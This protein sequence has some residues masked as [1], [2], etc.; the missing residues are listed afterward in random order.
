MV[1]LK[2]LLSN[3]WTYVVA[4]FALVIGLFFFERKE[5]QVAE[6]QVEI[7]K[8]KSQDAVLAF[9]QQQSQQD[10]TLQQQQIDQL[11]KE[12]PKSTDL[13]PQ[14]AEDYWKNKK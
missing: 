2:T 9:Q 3:I 1:Q 5:K 12:E 7:E 13:T 6:N 4:G 11:Q 14:Q 8:S 10:I